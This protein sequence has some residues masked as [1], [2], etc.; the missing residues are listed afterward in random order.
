MQTHVFVLGRKQVNQ[1]RRGVGRFLCQSVQ[2]VD[3]FELLLLPL[4][5]VG[6]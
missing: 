4:L 3:G 1:R 2:L 5:E 6:N